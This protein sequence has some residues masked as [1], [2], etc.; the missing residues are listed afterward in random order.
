[1]MNPIQSRLAAVLPLM[2]LL[3]AILPSAWGDE[4][5]K[6]TGALVIVGGGGM[7]DP[8]RD[9]F[10]ALA[11]GKG[12]AKIVVIPTASAL[13]DDKAEEAGYLTPWRKYDP[14]SLIFLHTRSRD[15]ANE[16]DFA[17]AIDDATAVWFSGGDQ[18]KLTAAYLDTETDK[19]IRRLLAR[20]GVVGGTSAGA[21]VMS[22]VMIEGGDPK[23]QVGRGFGFETRAVMDQHFLARSRINRLLGVLADHP[24]LIGLGIDEGT[25]FVVEGDRW[26]VVGK[27]YV[28]ACEV[29]PDGKPVRFASFSDGDHGT[30]P[31]KG[32]PTPDRG[33]NRED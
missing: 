13:A 31:A 24:T 30:F 1:M 12:A 27:S 22:A 5:T 8:V 3:G 23:A 32:L 4:P 6:K 19:A 14:A 10:V 16:P 21:A 18:S 26:S 9:R 33:K 11:G 28:L 29:G 7:P 17:K 15:R 25:A 20:G 2:F